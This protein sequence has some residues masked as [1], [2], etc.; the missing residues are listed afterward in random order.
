MLNWLIDAG[1]PITDTHEQRPFD[2]PLHM[3]CYQGYGPEAVKL[4]LDAGADPLQH[5]KQGLTA[6]GMTANQVGALLW[7]AVGWKVPLSH[8]PWWIKCL[9]PSL[10]HHEP[11]ARLERTVMPRAHREQ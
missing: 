10:M 11:L 2:Q 8:T 6:L 4:L 5:N 7:Q 1:I 3:A 9:V